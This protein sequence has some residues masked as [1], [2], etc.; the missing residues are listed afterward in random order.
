MGPGGAMGRAKENAAA[1]AVLN[2]VFMHTYCHRL[3][4]NASVVEK[5]VQL[6]RA[7]PASKRKD[8]LPALL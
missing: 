8:A 2:L 7:D 3:G 1:A 4:R 6:A 5:L